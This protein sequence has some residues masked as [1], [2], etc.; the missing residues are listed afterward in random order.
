MVMVA[1]SIDC[2][3][4]WQTTNYLNVSVLLLKL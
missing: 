1:L 4:S 3:P 2:T